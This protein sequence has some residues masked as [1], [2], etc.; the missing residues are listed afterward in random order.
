[1]SQ[2]N[3]IGLRCD[4]CGRPGYIT[5]TNPKKVVARKIELRKYCKWCRK[6]TPHKE[7]KFP[8]KAR[9]KKK[10]PVAKKAQVAVEKKPTV[11]KIPKTK[12]VKK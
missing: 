11:A 1:M 8:L 6:Q 2:N 5:H 10:A 7:A 3:L 12:E 4:N 9:P